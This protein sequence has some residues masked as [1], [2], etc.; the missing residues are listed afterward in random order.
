MKRAPCS[1]VRCGRSDAKRGLQ[2]QLQLLCERL[3]KLL[4][5]RMHERVAALLLLGE[6]LADLLRHVG[7]LGSDVAAGFER[8]VE[9]RLEPLD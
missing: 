9:L 3:L 4:H 1:Y 2:L 5:E 8:A 6:L 7:D